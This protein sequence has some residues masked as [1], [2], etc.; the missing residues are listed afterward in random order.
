MCCMLQSSPVSGMA[1]RGHLRGTALLAVAA[2]LQSASA[3]LLPPLP[4]ILSLPSDCGAIY[5]V[6]DGDSCQS[7]A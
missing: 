3:G 1:R 4:L 7:I 5:Q 2:L 6:Q